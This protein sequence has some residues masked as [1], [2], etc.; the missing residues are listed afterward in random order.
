MSGLVVCEV[1]TVAGF[2]YKCPSCRLKYCS[3]ACYKLHKETPCSRKS[4]LKSVVQPRVNVFLPSDDL[5]EEG[6]DYGWR[7]SQEQFH[8]LNSAE[9]IKSM[10]RDP[11]LQETIGKVDSEDDREGALEQ[12]RQ[13]DDRFKDFI[14]KMLVEIGVRDNE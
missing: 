2:K 12:A 7:L 6:E 13:N 9:W 14:D 4:P 11:A 3:V 1:C 8:K 5:E 10:L